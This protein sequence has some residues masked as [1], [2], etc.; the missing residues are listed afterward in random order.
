MIKIVQS[1]DDYDIITVYKELWF[2]PE[3]RKR[4]IQQGIDDEGLINQNRISTTVADTTDADTT[5]QKIIAGIYGRKFCFPL[6]IELFKDLPYVNLEDDITIELYFK[7]YDSV[8]IDPGVS[9]KSADGRYTITRSR[10][11]I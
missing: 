1:I 6:N 7:R 11:R 10:A 4:C 2:S 3:E 5:G 9:G 8:I